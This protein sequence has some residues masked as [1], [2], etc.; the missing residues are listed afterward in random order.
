MKQ[1]QKIV[2]VAVSITQILCAQTA[3]SYYTSFDTPAEQANWNIYRKGEISPFTW[4]VEPTGYSG[5]NCLRHDYPVASTSLTV[6]WYVSPVFNFAAGGNIDSLRVNF[7]GWSVP[8]NADTVALFLLTGSK[9]PA[10]A[11]SKTRLFDFRGAD[12]TNDGLWKLKTNISIPGKAGQSYIAFK[13]VTTSFWLDVKFDNLRVKANSTVGLPENSAEEELLLFPNPANKSISLSGGALSQNQSFRLNIYSLMGEKL[14][15]MPIVRGI[16]LD[17]KLSS[18]IYFYQLENQY[19][20][21]LNHGRIIV[22]S[23]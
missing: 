2:L 21:V 19:E 7:S 13:Y 3:T 4:T 6:D 9:D 23:D 17:H 8:S 22:K 16:P 20:E 12:Y 1:V 14:V 18:G 15:S 10:L 11:T 5:A